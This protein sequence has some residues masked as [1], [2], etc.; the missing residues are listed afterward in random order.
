MYS[1]SCSKNLTLLAICFS[2]PIA[3]ERKPPKMVYGTSAYQ[4][5]FNW[6]VKLTASIICC[7]VC[8]SSRDH[9][10]TSGK[11]IRRQVTGL[12][13]ELGIWIDWKWIVI[14]TNLPGDQFCGTSFFD[15]NQY[16]MWAIHSRWAYI[17]CEKQSLQTNF[18]I[19]FFI[20]PS[21]FIVIFAIKWSAKIK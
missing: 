6:N 9:M 16:V 21:R 8:R 4:I 19:L 10:P 7:P 1:S 3:Q 11:V 18:V 5:T 13:C 14:D 17:C 20:N 15:C 12:H 2:F